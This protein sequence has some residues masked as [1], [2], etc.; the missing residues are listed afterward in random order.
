MSRR[1]QSATLCIRL[2]ARRIAARGL[3]SPSYSAVPTGDPIYG[4]CSVP[5]AMRMGASAAVAGSLP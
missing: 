4:P 5:A 2:S 3:F 1:A